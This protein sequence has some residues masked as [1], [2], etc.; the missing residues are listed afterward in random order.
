MIRA[1]P[2]L[3]EDV[4]VVVG[5]LLEV[6]IQARVLF[7]HAQAVLYGCEVPKAQEVHLKKAK[8]LYLSH[9]ELGGKALVGCHKRHHIVH[10]FGR[11]DDACGVRPHVP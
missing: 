1:I 10:R 7:Y 3:F 5:D 11:D 6:Y 4:R 2:F 8:V 9:G